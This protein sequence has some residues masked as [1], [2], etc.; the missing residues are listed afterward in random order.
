MFN[1]VAIEG[2]LARPANTRELPSG[3][4]LTTME[5]TVRS[6]GNPTETVPLAWFDAPAWA[7]ELDTETEV[8]LSGRVR[9]RYFQT[10]GTTQSR[11]EVIVERLVRTK[12]AKGRRTLLAE[13]SAKLEAATLGT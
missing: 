9:R 13:A 12:S 1:V 11:T 8:V 7:G 2:V 5:V 6:A 4:R 10:A 3:S